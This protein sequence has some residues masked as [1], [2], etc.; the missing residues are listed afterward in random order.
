MDMMELSCLRI[1]L[2]AGELIEI[3][4]KSS[5]SLMYKGLCVIFGEI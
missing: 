2:I 1:G 5:E 3:E 4:L